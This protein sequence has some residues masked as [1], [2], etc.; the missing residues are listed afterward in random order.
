[1]GLPIRNP[2]ESLT[3]AVIRAVV[4]LDRS[5][6][7][8]QGPPGTGK[9]YTAARAIVALLRAGKRVGVSSNSHKA[10]TKLLSEVERHAS[11]SGFR[12][13]GVKK[14]NKDDP[15]TEFNSLNIATIFDSQEASPQHR[16]VGGTVFH[17]SRDDQR[18]TYDYLFVDEAGQVSLGNLVAMAGAAPKNLLLGGPRPLSPPAHGGDPR[19][20]RPVRPWD[21]LGGKASPPQGRGAL[22]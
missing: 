7:F 21:F 3:D 18:E 2:G 12:F 11:E 22:L 14:G 8:I 4:D 17:F 5:Y 16:L 1:D 13:S 19:E 15:E 20:T 10:I 9:T 6:L